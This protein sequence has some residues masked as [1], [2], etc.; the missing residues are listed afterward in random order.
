VKLAGS[1]SYDAEGADAGAASCE[2]AP[3][4]QAQEALMQQLSAMSSSI[5]EKEV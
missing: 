2:D 1:S 5:V 3:I 4:S